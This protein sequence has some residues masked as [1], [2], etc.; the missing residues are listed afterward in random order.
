[1]IKQ[2]KTGDAGVYDLTVSVSDG[3]LSDEK[4]IKLSV[5]SAN[6]A[7]MIEEISTITVKEGDTVTL[8]PKV[9]DPENEEMTITYSGWM[10]SDAKETG[11]DD[12]G[13][14][15][16]VVTVSDG[17]NTVSQE[18]KVVV[19]NVNRAPVFEIVN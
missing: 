1:M 5:G 7:P 17:Q 16:V 8:M 14:H 12:A 3:D 15:K 9:T 2:S 10:T 19:E 6:D 13:V 11:Y 18:V 4:T